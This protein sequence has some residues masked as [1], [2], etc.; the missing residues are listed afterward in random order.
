ME[1]ISIFIL[2]SRNTLELCW[3]ISWFVFLFHKNVFWC[4]IRFVILTAG[5]PLYISLRHSILPGWTFS[6]QHF[7]APSIW[8]MVA[9]SVIPV[10]Q[11]V[12]LCPHLVAICISVFQ[13][14]A[15]LS[16]G[17]I[18]S[19]CFF[20]LFFLEN[21]HWNFMQIV[22]SGNLPKLSKLIFW[23]KLEKYYQFV[24]YWICPEGGKD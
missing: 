6:R 7:Y 21:R 20:F 5:I 12:H 11:S 15:S 3:V 24:G 16:F 2:S 17:L 14:G 4:L 10:R 8:R 13:A 18:P 9:Y 22:S 19:C 1:Y 23:E